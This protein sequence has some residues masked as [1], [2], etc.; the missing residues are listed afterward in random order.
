MI[1]TY[2]KTIR[3][4]KQIFFVLYWF[5]L[6]GYIFSF[7]RQEEV[8]VPIALKDETGFEHL[9]AL[10]EAYPD[11][12]SEP[13]FFDNDWTI[14]LD[15]ERFYWAHGRIL[16]SF[17]KDRWEYFAPFDLYD[18]PEAEIKAYTKEEAEIIAKNLDTTCFNEKTLSRNVY[19]FEV[20][21]GIH[22]IE[23]AKELMVD[24]TFMGYHLLV[25]NKIAP[26][27]K[28]LETELKEMSKTDPEINEFFSSLFRIDGFNFRF[29]VDTQQLSLHSF[30][31][32]VDM[33]ADS[34]H[35]KAHYWYYKKDAPWYAIPK[36]NRWLFPTQI[37]DACERHNF[38]WGGKWFKYDSMHIEYR[39][40][41]FIYSKM[42]HGK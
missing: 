37:I 36:H 9:T 22:C 40:E 12:I 14:L 41:I 27:L 6:S 19:L 3:H 5:I 20:L 38:V 8:D 18:Y 13:V 17:F 7:G 39:P 2:L 28:E 35:G 25:H 29:V 30:G 26:K 42:T 23:S 15:N 24:T 21:Y 11:R 16:H 34:Y 32:A 31:I 10:H 4:R 33:L 1:K